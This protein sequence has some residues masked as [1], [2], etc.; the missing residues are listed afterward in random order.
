MNSKQHKQKQTKQHKK[1]Q[2]NYLHN[3][4]DSFQFFGGSLV[5]RKAVS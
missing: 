5:T 1:K 2:Q 4:L 3:T